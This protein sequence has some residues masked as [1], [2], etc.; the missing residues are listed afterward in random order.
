M[1]PYDIT[2]YVV[3]YFNPYICL[4]KRLNQ[5][6]NVDAANDADGNADDEVTGTA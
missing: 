1:F 4:V 3:M 6:A 2:N 5:K